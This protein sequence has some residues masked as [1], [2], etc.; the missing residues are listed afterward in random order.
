MS[1]LNYNAISKRE[2]GIL[3]NQTD[4]NYSMGELIYSVLRLKSIDLKVKDIKNISDEEF[5]SLTERAIKIE[6]DE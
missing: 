2:F 1:G 6:K 5:L 3:D 4:N